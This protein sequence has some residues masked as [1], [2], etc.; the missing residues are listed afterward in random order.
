MTG[1]ELIRAERHRQIC[2][3]GYLPDHDDAQTDGSI[4]S[5]A[6]AYAARSLPDWRPD[7]VSLLW[8][9]HIKYWKPAPPIRMLVKAGA[10][11]AAEIDRRLRA[12]ENP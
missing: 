9:W 1:V 11:I 7:V 2:D 8:P 12:G 10:L 6:A 3:E 4:A 5:A